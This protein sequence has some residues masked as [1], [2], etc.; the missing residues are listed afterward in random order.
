MAKGRTHSMS[1]SE[2]TLSV[3]MSIAGCKMREGWRRRAFPLGFL[4]IAGLL[5]WAPASTGEDEGPTGRLP[6]VLIES[7]AVNDDA[8]ALY[9]NPAALGRT[10]PWGLHVFFSGKRQAT[11]ES[12]DRW[13]GALSIGAT[14]IGFERER[15]GRGASFR[16]VSFGWGWAAA[17]GVRLGLRGTWQD[18]RRE[19]D[20]NAVPAGE[21]VRTKDSTWRWDLGMLYRPSRRLSCGLRV[22]D[23][24]QSLYFGEVLERRYRFGLGVRPLPGAW[25]TRATLFGD[26][27]AAE[28]SRWW[29]E[30]YAEAG[31]SVQVLPGIATEAAV[32]GRLDAFEA[33]RAWRIGLR[34]ELLHAS[35][36]GGTQLDRDDRADRQLVAVHVTGARQRTVVPAPTLAKMTLGGRYGDEAQLGLPLPIIGAPSRR[37]VRGVFEEL[38]RIESDPNVRGLLL[39]VNPISAGALTEELRARIHRV[40]EAG[41]PVVA[42]MEF[43][44]GWSQYALAAACDRIVLEPVS[45]IRRLGLRAEIPYLGDALDSLGIGIDKVRAGQYKTAFEEALRGEASGELKEALGAVLDEVHDGYVEAVSADRQLGLD[46]VGEWAD[47]RTVTSPQA[48][49]L[50]LVDSLGT[51]KDAESWLRELAGVGGA[52]RS[53]AGWTDRMEEWNRGPLVAVVW[54]DGIIESGKSQRGFGMVN[55]LGARTIAAQLEALANSPKVAA[56][57]L[58]IDSPGGSSLAS[59]QMWQAVERFRESGKPVVASLSRTAAS[60]GYFLAGAAD[61]IVSNASTLTG[62]IGVYVMKPHSVGLYDHLG[63]NV[64]VLER[65]AMMGLYSTVFPWTPGQRAHM[66]EMVDLL[67]ERFLDCMVKHRPLTRDQLDRVAQGRIWTGRAALEHGLVDRLGDLAVAIERARELAGLPED[68]EVLHVRR[69]RVSLFERVISGDGAL[70]RLAE[71]ASRLL[72]GGPLAGTA[73]EAEAAARVGESNWRAEVPW[74][75]RLLEAY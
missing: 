20:L 28:R 36:R 55:T 2:S 15:P 31:A 27:E 49:E 48:L 68:A 53:V 58:R 73:V 3:G 32:G 21:A 60:G 64:E 10:V 42:Y 14:G 26:V 33:T 23:I 46:Q 57:V 43:G 12:G 17:S 71:T 50:G 8:T 24:G 65:G 52:L 54:C 9:V 47:G 39:E 29:I 5:G 67:Y 40:R 18:A 38:D 56:L 35:V 59:D 44:S 51:R 74:L 41:K 72:P 11:A 30:S 1:G 37:G 69:P 16:R 75:S 13:G 62:S 25:R 7:V 34:F 19:V 45:A 4:L 22:Q 63:I 70:A 6:G 61:E 66:Q